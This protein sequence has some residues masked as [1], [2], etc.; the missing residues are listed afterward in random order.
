MPMCFL[1][2]TTAHATIIMDFPTK[3]L[4]DKALFFF[5][6]CTKVVIPGLPHT[7]NEA[8]VTESPLVVA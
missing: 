2:M 6:Q 1:N 5:C 8:R 3:M 7:T 4:L